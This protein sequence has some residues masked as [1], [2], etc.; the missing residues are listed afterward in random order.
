MYSIILKTRFEEN[1]GQI[2]DHKNVDQGTVD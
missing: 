2:P 1:L